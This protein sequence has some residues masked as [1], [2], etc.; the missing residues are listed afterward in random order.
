MPNLQPNGC[1][2]GRKAGIR[3]SKSNGSPNGRSAP[4]SLGATHGLETIHPFRPPCR[5][6]F[7]RSRLPDNTTVYDTCRGRQ[8]LVAKSPNK[9]LDQPKQ[10]PG[11]SSTEIHKRTKSPRSLLNPTTVGEVCTVCTLGRLIRALYGYTTLNVLSD[12][13]PT[14]DDASQSAEGVA[15][16]GTDPID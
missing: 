15:D 11:N 1:Q 10:D 14:R 12:Q 2:G 5:L 16:R 7:G 4:Y 6:R 8:V 13:S 9:P 3:L